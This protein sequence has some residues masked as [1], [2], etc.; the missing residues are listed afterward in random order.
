M[1]HGLVT[2]AGTVSHTGVGGLTL[3]GGFGRVARRFGLAL[4]NVRAVDIVTANGEIVH[5][6]ADENA[7]LYWGMRGGGGNFGVVTAFEFALH[8]MQRQVIGG[9]IVF[10]PNQAKSVLSFY[11]DYEAEAPDDLSL[12]FALVSNAGW[13]SRA[14]VAS[15]SSCATPARRAGRTR[16]C[17]GSARR[18]QARVRQPRGRSTTSRCSAP[19]T[20]TTRA[21]SAR[22]RRPAT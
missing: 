3:G 5:A 4:D 8:P 18:Q 12:D 2:T 9:R 10:P 15:A 17:A 11:S 13:D 19:E 21:R 1:A 6:N 16:S 14:P 7:D 20:S 22:T